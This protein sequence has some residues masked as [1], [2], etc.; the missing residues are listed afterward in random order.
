MTDY[1]AQDLSTFNTLAVPASARYFATATSIEEVQMACAWARDQQQRLLVLGSGSNIIPSNHIAALVLRPG[2]RG[3]RPIQADTES[4]WIEVGAGENWHQLVLHCLEQGWYGLEN[5]SLIP[6]TAGAAPIQNIG[7]YGVELSQVFESLQAVEI[8]TG[9]EETF[10]LE[11][12]AFGYRDS[13]FKNSLRG[14]YVVTS[15][16][17]RLS[18]LPQVIIRYPALAEALAGLDEQSITPLRVSEAV[19]ALR[20]SK[21]PDPL[22]IPNCGSF[23]KNPIVNHDHFSALREQYPD[24]VAFPMADGHKKL[25]AGWLIEKAGWK[26]RSHQGVV[27]HAQQALVLTNPQHLSAERVVAVASAIQEDVQRLFGVALEIEPQLLI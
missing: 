4:Q 3:I 27:V 19:C 10:D 20:R 17:L 26:G 24:L 7:A 18:R 16:R 14:C 8:A 13:I 12:C 23:F 15:I 9:R 6:G 11:R 2:I 21:L 1:K 25:A 5:L 22:E